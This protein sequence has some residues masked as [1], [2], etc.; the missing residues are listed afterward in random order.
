MRLI[1]LY[2]DRELVVEIPKGFMNLGVTSTNYL[3]GNTNDSANWDTFRFPLPPG[4]WS[5]KS[6]SENKKHVTLFHK[7]RKRTFFSP[8]Y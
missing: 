1:D 2:K 3:I 8:W 6:Y 4:D 5:I 7:A